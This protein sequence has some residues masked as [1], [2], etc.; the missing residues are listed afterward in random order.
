[1]GK[2]PLMANTLVLYSLCSEHLHDIMCHGIDG[3][4]VCSTQTPSDVLILQVVT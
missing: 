3:L 1:M 2:R 4:W